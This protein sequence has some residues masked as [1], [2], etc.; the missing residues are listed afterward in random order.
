MSAVVSPFDDPFSIERTDRLDW[1]HDA[2]RIVG[3][4]H[5]STKPNGS[6]MAPPLHAVEDLKDSSVHP[7]VSLF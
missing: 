7:G 5:S 3:M 4:S 6:I 1:E 2:Q